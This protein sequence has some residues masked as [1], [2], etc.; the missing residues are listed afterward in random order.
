MTNFSEKRQ[1][2][3]R[4]IYAL[5]FPNNCCY[6]GQSVNL[7]RRLAQH[8]HRNGKWGRQTFY[9]VRL[10]K[11]KGTYADAEDLECAWRCCAQRQGWSIYGL[12]PN[13]VVDPARRLNRKRSQLLRQCV[14]PRK[15]RTV[16]R[17]GA[18]ILKIFVGVGIFL[19]ICAYMNWLPYLLQHIRHIIP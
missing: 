17:A 15:Y 8:R 10:D 9:M 4:H 18:G 12:P 13:I 7:N 2:R 1:H 11:I 5:L 14:W 6:I 19:G 3:I 16:G